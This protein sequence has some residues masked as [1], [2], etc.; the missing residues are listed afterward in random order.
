[1]QDTRF[2]IDPPAGSDALGGP[3]EGP[4]SRV[5]SAAM[6]LAAGSGGYSLWIWWTAYAGVMALLSCSLDTEELP[7]RPE[8]LADLPDQLWGRCLAFWGIE[9]AGWRGA[10]NTESRRWLV[11]ARGRLLQLLQDVVPPHVDGDAADAFGFAAAASITP[12]EREIMTMV[13]AGAVTK[14]IAA[15]LGISTK[16]VEFHRANLR[17]KLGARNTLQAMKMLFER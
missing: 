8:T 4:A 14:T 13:A 1:M 2:S 9:Y 6:Q 10:L 15:R 17:R 3:Q 12:R 5:L 11:D 7:I 16:T